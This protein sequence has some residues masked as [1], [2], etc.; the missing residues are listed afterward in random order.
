MGITLSHGSRVPT[1]TIDKG[2]RLAAARQDAGI[3]QERMAELLNCSRRTI[4]RYESDDSVPPAVVMAYSMATDV[5]LAWLET[6]VADFDND[7]D[8]FTAI[9]GKGS[10]YTPRDLNP[11]PTDYGSVVHVEFGRAPLDLGGHA[12]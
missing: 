5:N 2:M 1:I 12:A 4:T 11:E 6:G 7:G 8:Y 9:A 3:T 10:R